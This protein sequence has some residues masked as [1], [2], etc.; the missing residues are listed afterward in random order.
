MFFCLSLYL[1]SGIKELPTSLK[2]KRK[3]IKLSF[4]EEFLEWFNHYAE[5][6][7]ED[8]KAFKELYN[9]FMIENDFDKKDYSQKRFKK[10]LE[11]AG[12][13]FGHR[14]QS[15]RNRVQNNQNENRMLKEGEDRVPDEK[16][17]LDRVPDKL[18]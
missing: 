4:T 5:N 2:L 7:C 6:G 17:N 16:I 18:F 10:G 8:W 3:Q 1:G 13:T 14:V 15:R 12:E 11:V 9:S